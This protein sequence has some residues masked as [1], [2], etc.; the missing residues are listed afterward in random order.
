MDK[1]LLSNKFA[2]FG[3]AGFKRGHGLVVRQDCIDERLRFGF[4]VSKC[5]L[6]LIDCRM[7]QRPSLIHDR[8][9]VAHVDPAPALRAADVTV[10]RFGFG[11][12]VSL[13]KIF[14]TRNESHRK[15]SLTRFGESIFSGGVVIR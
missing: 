5:S 13:I 11:S 12:P 10:C 9:K 1:S 8:T 6:R 2:G 14:A 7:W 15:A 3:S 4:H